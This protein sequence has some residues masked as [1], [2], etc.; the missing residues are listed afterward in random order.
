A[1]THGYELYVSNVPLFVPLSFGTVVWAGRALVNRAN[2]SPG[3]LI[4]GGALF[5]A[6]IDLVIDPMT[7]RGGTWFLGSLYAYRARGQWFNVPWTNYAGWI[8]VG[9]VILSV[10]ALFEARAPKRVDT[11]RGPTLAY[12]MCAF[13]VVIALATSH[14]AIAAAAAGVTIVMMSL[15]RALQGRA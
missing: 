13:F 9:A 5:A 14:W 7:L 10:D 3:V 15:A 1:S 8:L 12:G 11:A 2:I 4:L 6:A